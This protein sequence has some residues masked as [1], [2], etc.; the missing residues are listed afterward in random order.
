MQPVIAY[1]SPQ[2]LPSAVH[3]VWFQVPYLPVLVLADR[4][5][6]SGA[7]GAEGRGQGGGGQGAH[8]SPRRD[9]GLDSNLFWR[10]FR[11]FFRPHLLE[12]QAHF[13]SY[14]CT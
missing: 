13:Y 10:Y 14:M 5:V 4:P 7:I 6:G 2:D 3:I 12:F 8:T 1:R 9:Q 11:I